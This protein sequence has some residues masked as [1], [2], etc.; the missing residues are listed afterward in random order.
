MDNFDLRKYLTENKL[1]TEKSVNQK[2]RDYVEN[3][4]LAAL[5]ERLEELYREMEQEAEP[6]GG[7][8]ADQYAD[9]ITSVEDAIRIKKGTFGNKRTYDDVFPKKSKS[10]FWDEGNLD[11]FEA[12][13]FK[14]DWENFTDDEK[15]TA[16]LAPWIITELNTNPKKIIFAVRIDNESKIIGKSIQNLNLPRNTSV[17]LIIR[18]II[19][20][21][22]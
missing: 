21:H 2:T 9:E 6:E 13:I 11:L 18:S 16:L 12:Q 19:I 5:G 22:Y 1:L 4:S 14:V 17:I 3:W 10:S 15:E 8:V 20:F 7:P